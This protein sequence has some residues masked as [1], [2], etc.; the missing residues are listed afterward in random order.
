M[1]Y[2]NEEEERQE[3]HHNIHGKMDI[4]DIK[5][6]DKV[7]GQYVERDISDKYYCSYVYIRWNRPE[8]KKLLERKRITT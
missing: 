2:R 3:A 4:P 6:H 7:E 5:E 8:Y 1:C